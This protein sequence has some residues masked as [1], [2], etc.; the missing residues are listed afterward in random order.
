MHKFGC[1]NFGCAWLAILNLGSGKEGNMVM[2]S[3]NLEN[4]NDG[5][6]VVTY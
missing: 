2:P 1:L 5:E 6:L 3:P 4:Q